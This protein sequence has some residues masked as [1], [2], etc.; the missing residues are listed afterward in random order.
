MRKDIVKYGFEKNY[1]YR[2]QKLIIDS[3]LPIKLFNP[4]KQNYRMNTL[5]KIRLSED[6]FTS[7]MGS[8]KI[9]LIINE[10]LKN[11][12]HFVDKK[13]KLFKKKKKQLIGH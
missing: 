8:T 9:V 7:D 6:K 11:N 4:G 5:K 1:G 2:S 3:K 12:N 10:E 13:E